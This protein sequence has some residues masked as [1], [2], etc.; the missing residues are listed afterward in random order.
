MLV[1][2]T[3]ELLDA[4]EIPHHKTLGDADEGDEIRQDEVVDD[5]EPQQSATN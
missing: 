4:Q 1:D 2:L 5:V 3:R